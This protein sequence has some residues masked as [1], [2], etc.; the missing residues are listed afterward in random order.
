MRGSDRLP[1]GTPGDREELSAGWGGAGPGR[2]PAT[3][4][5]AFTHSRRCRPKGRVPERGHVPANAKDQVLSRV[6]PV[7]RPAVSPPAE[8]LGPCRKSLE[9]SLVPQLFPEASATPSLGT[10]YRR[11]QDIKSHKSR[12]ERTQALLPG[13]S[14]SGHPLNGSAAVAVGLAKYKILSS[15]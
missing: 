9:P 2:P 10:T 13:Y 6:C 3:G 5:P 12:K 14:I 1:P 8:H 15:P 4:G 7:R 11:A